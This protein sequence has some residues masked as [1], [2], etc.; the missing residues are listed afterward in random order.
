MGIPRL[1]ASEF[2][3]NNNRIHSSHLASLSFKIMN[4]NSNADQKKNILVVDD[5]ENWRQVIRDILEPEGYS[6]YDSPDLSGAKLL[7]QSLQF[8]VAILDLRLVDQYPFGFQGLS[9]IQEVKNYGIKAVILTGYSNQV[10]VE[11]AKELG[12]DSFLEKG[13]DFN[14]HMFRGIIRNFKH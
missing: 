10:L 13:P 1:F 7:L 2:Q 9:L 6:V 8:L 12:V 4:N 3:L 14:I 11:K 5:Q